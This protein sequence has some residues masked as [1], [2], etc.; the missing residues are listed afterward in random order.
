VALGVN[1]S[2]PHSQAPAASVPDGPVAAFYG[3]SF[4]L[5]TGAGDPSKRWSTR[6]SA[7]RGWSEY[8]PSVNGLGFVN[9]RDVF[10]DGDLPA[11]IIEQDPDIVFITMGLNDNFS[12]DFA[13]DEIEAQITSDLER[14][15]SA[16]PDARFIVVEPFW[17]ARERPESVDVIIGWVRSAAGKIG[18]DYIAGASRWIEGEEEWM[19]LDGLHPNDEGYA[20]M[21]RRM[22]GELQKLGL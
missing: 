12:Y 22:D 9:N 18:A 8:N 13:A 10:G 16:L 3:D 19:A 17:Y 4:T 7:E 2:A 14:I 15:S 5:G 21:T 1:S 6:I 20:E 11:L